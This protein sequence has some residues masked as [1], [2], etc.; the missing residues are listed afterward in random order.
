MMVLSD[1]IIPDRLLVEV[2]NPSRIENCRVSV[3]LHYC[4]IQVVTERRTLA[5][6]YI[7]FDE[8]PAKSLQEKL[9][10]RA[11][12]SD[13]KGMLYLTDRLLGR[14]IKELWIIMRPKLLPQVRLR[15]GIALHLLSRAQK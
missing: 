5:P 8:V 11:F 4:R 1:K 2:R 7:S 3:L 14:S 6:S 12:L 10:V 9:K 15:F 13:R